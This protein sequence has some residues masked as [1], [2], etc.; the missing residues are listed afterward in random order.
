VFVALTRTR[1]RAVVLDMPKQMNVYPDKASGR[2][3]RGG[4]QRWM[5]LGFEVRG[6]DTRTPEPIGGAEALEVQRRLQRDVRQGDPIHFV[7]APQHSTLQAPVYRAMHN[8]EEI[9]RTSS[10]FGDV[11][12]RR[13]G[14]GAQRRKGR[15]WP[16][17]LGL[18]VDGVETVAGPPQALD[19]A[20]GAG[21]W[22]LWASVRCSGLAELEW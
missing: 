10:A 6:E 20:G 12:V 11:L 5:T 13:V 15:P 3:V 4:F 7:L 18:V 2:W 8:G 17:L 14:A 21:R 19:R 9:G 16:N 22:G 1:D